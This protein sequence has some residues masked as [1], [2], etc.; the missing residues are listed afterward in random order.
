MRL[1]FNKKARFCQTGLWKPWSDEAS[2][3]REDTLWR[4][5]S[6][7][8]GYGGVNLGKPDQVSQTHVGAIAGDFVNGVRAVVG[9]HEEFPASFAVAEA[10]D[11]GGCWCSRG[12]KSKENH[13]SETL[14][15]CPLH[16]H[17]PIWGVGRS[18]HMAKSC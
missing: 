14:A 16:F 4:Q 9:I 1:I 12:N 3:C 7:G 6:V 11:R 10:E 8:I 17:H 5:L 13:F 15:T 18:V 2:W